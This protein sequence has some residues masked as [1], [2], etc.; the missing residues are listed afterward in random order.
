MTPERHSGRAYERTH[1]WLTFAVD[2]CRLRPSDWLALGECATLCERISGAPL[3]PGV[4]ERLRLH[5]MYL[6][7]G[8]LATTAIKGNTLSEE[9]ARNRIEGRLDLP[10]SQEYLGREIDNIVEAVNGLTD[11]IVANG[12]LSLSVASV[13][14]MNG[15]VL[16]NLEADDHVVPGRTRRADVS[17]GSCRCPGWQDAE[18]LLARFCGFIAAF[19]APTG[20][21]LALAILK[22]AAAHVYMAWIHPFVDGNGRTA[23]L[24]EWA[25]LMEAGMSQPACHLLSNYYN[26]TRTEYYRQLARASRADNGIFGFVSYAIEGLNEELRGQ[27][28]EIRGHR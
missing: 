12:R 17:V 14:R 6:A 11:A 27:V 26:R 20:N 19:E 28:R 7:K 9:E 5:T 18:Y 21:R 23:R 4:A 2:F 13:E 1:P 16:R 8:A 10:P 24:V 15:M 22:A 25:I 3:D